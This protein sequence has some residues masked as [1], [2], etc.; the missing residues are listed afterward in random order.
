VSGNN[1]ETVIKSSLIDRPRRLEINSEFIEFENSDLKE[2]LSTRIPRGGV[3]GFRYGLKWIRGYSF[4]IGRIY[5]IDIRGKEQLFKIR[6]YSIYGIRR[7]QLS[8]KFSLILNAFF[9]THHEDIVREYLHYYSL[10]GAVSICGAVFSNEGVSL[11]EKS[12]IKWDDLGMRS[13]ST[14]HALF[15]KSDPTIYKAFS[16]L[17]DW[18]SAAVYSIAKTLLA[19]KGYK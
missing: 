11:G 6:L 5:C 12:F 7:K 17:L 10:E 18:N 19:E 14:Y 16:Y 15:S 13:Y 3:T 1:L 8:K 4:Y 9:D 2:K